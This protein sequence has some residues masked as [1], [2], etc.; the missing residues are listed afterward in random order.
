MAKIKAT[1]T[2]TAKLWDAFR[3]ACLKRKVSASSIL[4]KLIERQLTEWKET[5]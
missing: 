4:D 1:I 3:I 2:L 5:K